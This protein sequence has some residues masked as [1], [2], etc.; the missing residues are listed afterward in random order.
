MGEDITELHI[1][2]AWGFCGRAKM[3]IL[4]GDLWNMVGTEKVRV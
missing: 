4:W 1:L 3:K 2:K